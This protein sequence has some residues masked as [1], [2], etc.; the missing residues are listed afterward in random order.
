MPDVVTVG[1]CGVQGPQK[2]HSS[3]PLFGESPS[4]AHITPLL[5]ATC[6][7]QQIGSALLTIIDF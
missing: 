4:R 3:R 1:S 2:T 7:E 6:I 5:I